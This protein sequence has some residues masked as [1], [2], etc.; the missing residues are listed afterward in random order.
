MTRTELDIAAAAAVIHFL[1]VDRGSKAY[2]VHKLPEAVP[3]RTMRS[4][5][6]RN[7]TETRSELRWGIES[8]G[9]W[10][11]AGK[12][13]KQCITGDAFILTGYV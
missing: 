3:R 10:R 6:D 8:A 12:V 1:G 13:H 4:P 7:R 5:R 2:S 11:T 9:Y